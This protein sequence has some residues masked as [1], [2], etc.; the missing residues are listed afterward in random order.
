MVYFLTLAVRLSTQ[1]Y[2]SRRR[3]VPYHVATC[4]PEIGLPNVQKGHSMYVVGLLLRLGGEGREEEEREEGDGGRGGSGEGEGGIGEGEKAEGTG[5]RSIRRRRWKRGKRMKRRRNRKRW[6]R[7]G[8]EEE[9][10]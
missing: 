2:V 4:R 5:R 7:T 3:I 10:E 1:K 8:N 9:K 6:K